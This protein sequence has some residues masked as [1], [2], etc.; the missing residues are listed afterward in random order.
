ML[1]LEV[2]QLEVLQLGGLPVLEVGM[3]KILTNETEPKKS[4]FYSVYNPSRCIMLLSHKVSNNPACDQ[5]N[6][7]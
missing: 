2:L 5:T 6:M 7:P 1:Q 4:Y 3:N